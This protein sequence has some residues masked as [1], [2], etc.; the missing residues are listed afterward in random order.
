MESRFVGNEYVAS[1]AAGA[2]GITHGRPK[3]DGLP[4]HARLTV[5]NEQK[6]TKGGQWV[7]ME[8]KRRKD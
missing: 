2:R 3:S 5:F 1:T 8:A 7:R 6:A 4:P